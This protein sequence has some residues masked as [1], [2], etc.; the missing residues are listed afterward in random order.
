MTGSLL[1]ATDAPAFRLERPLGSSPYLLVCDHA[2]NARPDRL[3]TLGLGYEA[4]SAHVA[5]D[6]G[7]AGVALRLSHAL[8]ACCVL[9]SYS[10]LVIDCN[11]EPGTVQSIVT[12]SE[13]TEIPGNR[14]LSAL[15]RELRER[16]IFAPYH[17]C[18][19][20]QLDRRTAQ[21][22]PTLFCSLHSFT[23]SYL[24]VSRPWHAAVLYDRDPRLAHAL[25]AELREEPGLVIGDNEPYSVSD[26]T[27][28]TVIVHAERRGV[29]Y[30]EI[31]IRQDL[32][33]DEAGQAVWA[34]RLGRLLPTLIASVRPVTPR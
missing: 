7:I 23:P 32:I 15:D 5:W 28:Y 27:D 22:V 3:G 21:H 31:E 20:E 12:L 26:A 13:R 30:L 14:E 16:E 10:R 25:R 2:S 17:G 1:T 33:A 24:G 4:L 19:S 8:D 18:I 34:E 9:Q 29:P 6:I 11:R